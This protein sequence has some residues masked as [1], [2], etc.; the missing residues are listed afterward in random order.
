M[1]TVDRFEA[2]SGLFNSQDVGIKLKGCA[3]AALYQ[4]HVAP[5]SKQTKNGFG[6]DMCSKLARVT[7]TSVMASDSLQQVTVD[8]NERTLRWAPTYVPSSHV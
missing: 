4:F 1:K 2:L 3:A 6:R 8:R 7:A 5:N